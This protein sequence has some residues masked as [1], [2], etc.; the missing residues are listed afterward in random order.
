VRL[1]TEILVREGL[2][3]TEVF[4]AADLIPHFKKSLRPLI[5]D[6]LSKIPDRDQDVN[7]DPF[8]GLV[9]P[10]EGVDD[11]DDEVLANELCFCIKG[12]LSDAVQLRQRLHGMHRSF[13]LRF[14][15]LGSKSLWGFPVEKKW[16]STR[17]PWELTALPSTGERPIK[18]VQLVS[19]PMLVYSGGW[20]GWEE[21]FHLF[22]HGHMGVISLWCDGGEVMPR[23]YRDVSG[24]KH[25]WPVHEKD[26]QEQEQGAK[27]KRTNQDA[28]PEQ[29]P[30]RTRES[31]GR[32]TR[33]TSAKG[34]VR[35]N[36]GARNEKE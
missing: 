7:F 36:E 11:V 33:S 20:E 9:E 35:L 29:R 22:R 4:R 13:S 27:P 10:P 17:D 28:A 3:L 18:T 5:V 16:M 23:S 26:G 8:D 14:S 12:L 34:A 6:G 25:V 30:K 15:P 31:V 19:D 32:V 2:G 1:A 24:V 21:D